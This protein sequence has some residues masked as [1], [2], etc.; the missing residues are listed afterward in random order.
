MKSF[1]DEVD[2]RTEVG[3]GTR[4]KLLKSLPGNGNADK[5]VKN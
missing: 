2:V 3:K 5:F 1:M 4:V